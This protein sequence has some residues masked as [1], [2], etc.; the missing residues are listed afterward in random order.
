MEDLFNVGIVMIALKE[1]NNI[2]KFSVTLWGCEWQS[3]PKFNSLKQQRKMVL[4]LVLV[5]KY[6]LLE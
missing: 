1:K 3:R 6:Q 2:K 4:F 5:F